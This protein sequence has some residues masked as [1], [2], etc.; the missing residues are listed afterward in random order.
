MCSTLTKALR[1]E[2]TNVPPPLL[3]RLVLLLTTLRHANENKDISVFFGHLLE[4]F[5]LTRADLETCI[6]DSKAAF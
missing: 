5:T 1:G 3:R 2:N 6:S 4:Q